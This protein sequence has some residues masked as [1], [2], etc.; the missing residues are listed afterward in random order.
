MSSMHPRR[1]L[2]RMALAALLVGAPS[3]GGDSGSPTPTPTDIVVTPGADTLFSL[4]ASRAFTAQ[5]LDANGHPLDAAVVTW[6]SSAP[7][8]LSI[9]AGTGVATAV[10]NGST[11][12]TATSGT[13]HGS[14][15]AFVVQIVTSVTVTPSNAALTAVGDTVRFHA[16]P[17]DSL[18]NP[19]PSAQLLWSVNDNAVAIIDTLGLA[20]AKGP[21]TVLVSAQAQ[22]RAGYAA[23]GVSQAAAKV[24]ITDAPTSGVAGKMFGSAVQVEVRDS[25]DHRLRN[26]S[27][28]VTIGIQGG[29]G[30]YGMRGVY[31]LTTVD[32]AAS[33]QNLGATR[34]GSLRLVAS[35]PGIDTGIGP[36]FTIDPSVP[37]K[38]KILSFADSQRVGDSLKASVAVLDSFE[39]QTTA[40]GIAITPKL[41][42]EEAPG[43]WFTFGLDNDFSAPSVN[44]VVLQFSTVP[45]FVASGWY[46]SVTSPGLDSA[47]AG[48]IKVTPGPAIKVILYY[49]GAYVQQPYVGVGTPRSPGLA[50]YITDL[51]GNTVPD[52]PATALTLALDSW[53]YGTP[54]DPN[55]TQQIAGT[56]SGT[57]T[58]GV[59]AF[60][61]V[62]FRRVGATQLRVLSGGTYA[63]PIQDVTVGRLW[64]KHGIAVGGR[65]ACLLSDGGPACW[66]DNASGQLTGSGTLDTIARPVVGA[67]ALVSLTAGDAHT[68][69]LT[70][71]GVA[72]CWGKNSSGQLGRSSTTASEPVPVAVSGPVTFSALV[73][74]GDHTCGIAIADSTAWCWGSNSSGEVGDSTSTARNVPTPVF[75]GLKF[76]QIAAGYD[77]T[78]GLAVGANGTAYCWGDNSNGQAGTGSLLPG[79]IKAP[80]VVSMDSIETIKAGTDFTCALVRMPTGDLNV[81]C[82]GQGYLG[83]LGDAAVSL[84]NHPSPVAIPNVGAATAGGLILGTANACALSTFFWYCWGDNADHQFSGSLNGV[85]V[86]IPNFSG[87]LPVDEL[88]IGD[89]VV[90]A[91]FDGNSGTYNTTYCSGNGNYGQRG[92]GN[93]FGH[94]NYDPADQ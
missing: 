50:A 46:L 44:G 66:G 2:R 8:V 80:A 67:P 57:T 65:H 53:S 14:A 6:S 21:G 15:N 48:P 77:H 58:N 36:Q 52:A 16:V 94:Q 76:R 45:T 59:L 87:S 68:C 4:G 24:V 3:C 29:N 56:I 38:L 1:A 78:C 83:R 54:A 30:T 7:E 71:A 84:S 26:A 73:A 13:L 25:N 12:V 17:K 37:A 39:N 51:F 70:S 69:G 18:G 47:A 79:A 60:P 91:I 5:V 22:T 92:Y 23:L 32:G 89:A 55:L 85:T 34:A 49:S 42:Y 33:F 61:D 9:D 19:V 64:N 90:C 86:P 75:G 11:Q 82:W 81:W 40:N 35:A 28:P 88:G 43:F 31:T 10:A 20:T 62:Q 41:S 72:W 74:G 27:I 63:S 93:S